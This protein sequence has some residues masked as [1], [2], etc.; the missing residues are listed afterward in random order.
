MRPKGSNLWFLKAFDEFPKWNTVHGPNCAVKFPVYCLRSS[1]CSLSSPIIGL[2]SLLSPRAKHM[3]CR[4]GGPQSLWSLFCKGGSREA[5]CKAPWKGRRVRSTLHRTLLSEAKRRA[6]V[7]CP[8][9]VW[10]VL[11]RLSCH[12]SPVL[13]RPKLPR[14]LWCPHLSDKM[15]EVSISP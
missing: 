9:C 8:P 4:S 5:P 15:T 13:L 11:V 12:P 14:L 3:F 10:P 7:L 1:F 6:R 2:R